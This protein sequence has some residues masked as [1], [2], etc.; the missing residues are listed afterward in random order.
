[1]DV[2]RLSCSTWSSAPNPER[3]SS[4][5]TSVAA[6]R[7]GVTST[8]YAS[9]P[10]VPATFVP[11]R[12][13]G[14]S[15]ASLHFT[16]AAAGASVGIS[17]PAAPRARSPGSCVSGGGG[18]SSCITA[19]LGAST[20]GGAG[21]AATAFSAAASSPAGREAASTSSKT[22]ASISAATGCVSIT[23][24]AC[25]SIT[26]SGRGAPPGSTPVRAK[27]PTKAKTSSKATSAVAPCSTG[28]RQLCQ[29][30]RAGSTD[31]GMV[32]TRGSGNVGSAWGPL[33]GL[34]QRV[35]VPAAVLAGGQVGAPQPCAPGPLARCPGRL[36]VVRRCADVLFYRS[37]FETNSSNAAPQG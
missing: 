1:M 7:V 11:A 4:L 5:A 21:A 6:S 33:H 10:S 23:S 2:P 13:N 17:N 29:R 26:A 35:Q 9:A 31:A 20:S 18:A 8:L 24:T 16:A 14:A 19:S 12:G 30:A 25:C 34:S 37:S 28:T 15:L 3:S 27:S 36:K 32:K 22:V